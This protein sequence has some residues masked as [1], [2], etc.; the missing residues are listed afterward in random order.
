M[1]LHDVVT[2]AVRRPLLVLLGA[3]GFVVLLA[4]VNLAGLQL[5]RAAGRG[6]EIGVRVALGARRGRL[7]R[8]LLTE[9]LVLAVLRRPR[10]PGRRE[11][12]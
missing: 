3:V 12:V 2:G 6:R 5:A 9:S 8:Q 7:V 4:C 10:R 11:P 1:P